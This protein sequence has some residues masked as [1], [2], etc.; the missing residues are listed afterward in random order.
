MM[1][2]V[3]EAS[4]LDGP[5]P[6]VLTAAGVLGGVLV[7]VARARAW[8]PRAVPAVLAAVAAVVAALAAVTTWA[9]SPFPDPLPATVWLCLGAAAAALG[10]AAVRWTPRSGHGLRARV[11]AT[12]GALLVLAAAAEGVNLHYGAFPTVRTAVGLPYDDEVEFADTPVHA[13][14]VSAPTPGTPFDTTWRPPRDMPSNGRVAQV[15][16]PPTAS[17]FAARPAWIYLPPAYLGSTRARLPVLVLMSGQPGSPDDWL[18]GG[19][20]AARMDTFAA[21]HHG[22]A[23]I[24]LMPDALGSPLANPLCLDSRLGDVATYLRVDV[25]A[26]IRAHLEA[27]PPAAVGGLSY[28]GTCA[29]QTALNAP[30]VY[31]DLLD[32]SGQSEPTL[33]TRAQT[34][35]AAFG[36]DEAAFRA[37]N[38]LD[39]LATR[40]FPGT[41]AYLVAGSED[42]DYRPQAEQ[43]YAA[44]RAAHVPATLTLLPGGHSWQVWGPGLEAAL[45][46]LAGRLGLT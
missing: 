36:G 18:A 1:A 27:Q 24:V 42:A 8:W 28:G 13:A 26:W 37:V 6:G 25:P 31:P 34:V 17:G 43:V 30:G 9:W 14:R 38:P 44:L 21:A 32:I 19:D 7:L 4:L 16:I 2:V 29:L 45:P 33:G 35:A 3:L 46:W 5:V 10:L 11:A 40:A 41:Q 22:L 39:L 23:P 15:T 12:V 20:L